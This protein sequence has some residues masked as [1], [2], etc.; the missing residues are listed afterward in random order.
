MVVGAWV[1]VLDPADDRA[2]PARLHYVSPMK[3]H[4]LFVDRK[5]LKVYECSRTMLARRVRL[6]EVVLLDGEPDAS[7]FDRIMEGLFGKL[8][9][10]A[11]A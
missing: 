8:K 2:R 5:G 6:G 3:S 10:P 9:Q 1:E 11:P 4:F 7:F